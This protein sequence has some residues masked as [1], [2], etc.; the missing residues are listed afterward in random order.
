MRSPIAALPFLLSLATATVKILYGSDLEVS[1]EDTVEYGLQERNGNRYIV[2]MDKDGNNKQPTTII[3]STRETPWKSG[4]LLVRVWGPTTFKYNKG[5][6]DDDIPTVSTGRIR[7]TP[8]NECELRLV[9]S[10]P[11][12]WGYATKREAQKASSRL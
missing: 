9:N 1:E 10:V 2:T 12:D 7:V 5:A 11:D 8:N 6:V 3:H 4:D